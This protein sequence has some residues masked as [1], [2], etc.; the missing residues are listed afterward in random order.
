MSVTTASMDKGADPKTYLEPNAATIKRMA[1]E[2]AKEMFKKMKAEAK[3]EAKAKTKKA[4]NTMKGKHF[5]Y[6]MSLNPSMST[7]KTTHVL[8]CIS[9]ICSIYLYLI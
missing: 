1:V 8:T 6:I 5:T 2:M 7:N 9:L 4:T 3:A